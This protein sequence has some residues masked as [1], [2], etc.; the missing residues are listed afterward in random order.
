MTNC[1]KPNDFKPN[2]IKPSD[3]LPISWVGG[4]RS[5]E[6]DRKSELVLRSTYQIFEGDRNNSDRI[7]LK[8]SQICS[9]TPS[10]LNAGAKRS[11]VPYG[12]ASMLLLGEGSEATEPY[13]KYD[14]I[15][16]HSIRSLQFD[17]KVRL[18]SFRPIYSHPDTMDLRHQSS[19]Q[20]ICLQANFNQQPYRKSLRKNTQPT[21]NALHAP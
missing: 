15:R 7:F 13:N 10:A 19:Q 21:S 18:L 16:L 20:P 3:H 5:K 4:S 8:R 12:H 2:G 11:D 17:R 1:I 6:R 9:H 14:K